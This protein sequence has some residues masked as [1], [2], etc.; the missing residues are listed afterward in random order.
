MK[1]IVIKV[2]DKVLWYEQFKGDIVWYYEKVI[3][4]FERQGSTTTTKKVK[5]KLNDSNNICFDSENRGFSVNTKIFKT[6]YTEKII[7]ADDW[8]P[9]SSKVTILAINPTQKELNKQLLL[10]AL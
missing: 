9:Y 7:G 4:L 10:L 2:G 1:N 8:S 3:E 6:N 5:L